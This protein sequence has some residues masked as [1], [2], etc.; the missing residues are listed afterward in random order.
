[1]LCLSSAEST[2]ARHQAL[3][4]DLQ[5]QKVEATRALLEEVRCL[6][7]VIERRGVE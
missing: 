2:A 5:R 6:Q 4:V 7:V 3:P 1:M